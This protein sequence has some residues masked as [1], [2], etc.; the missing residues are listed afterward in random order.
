MYSNSIF[1][2]PYRLQILILF[3][4]TS[5]LQVSQARQAA[6]LPKLEIRPAKCVSMRQ[7]QACYIKVIITWQA[8]KT[9]EYCLFSSQQVKPLKC[10]ISKQQAT[11]THH[12]T[13]Q[14]DVKYTLT[15]KKS[16]EALV[17]NTLILAWVYKKEKFSHSSWR[18]F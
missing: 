14:Q 7:K 16:G 11:F 18:I 5:F 6:V 1:K 17:N 2:L 10:W 9:D 12:I 15:S 8:I 3:L 4:L 13:M